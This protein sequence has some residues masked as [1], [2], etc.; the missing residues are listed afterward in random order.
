VFLDR[1]PADQYWFEEDGFLYGPITPDL[2]QIP[3]EATE[4]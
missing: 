4:G 1:T 3:D 2:L